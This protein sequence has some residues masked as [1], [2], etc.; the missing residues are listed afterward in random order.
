M[1]VWRESWGTSWG[2]SWAT[3]VQPPIATLVLG[4]VRIRPALAGAVT[5]KTA[6]VADI[7]TGPLLAARI[8]MDRQ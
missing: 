5:M 1:N 6:M 7:E 8:E 3:A 4:A 2:T